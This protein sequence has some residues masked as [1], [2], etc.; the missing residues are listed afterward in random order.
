MAT[1]KQ[2]MKDDLQL[3]GL[4]PRT[5]KT[6]IVQVTRFARYFNKL[7]DKLGEKEVKEYLL[8]L[9]NEKHVSYA[10]LAQSYSALKFIYEVTLQ[11]PW[12]VKR[13]PYPKTPRKLPVVLNKEEIAAIFSV[14]TNLKHRA[15]LMMTYSAGLRISEVLHLHLSDIDRARMTVLVRQG[16]GKKDR[17]SLLSKVALQTLDEYLQRYQPRTWLFPS[18][19]RDQPF[20]R[21][22]FR[23]C[24][25][26][27]RPA[28][29]SPNRQRCIR[30]D[31][32]LPL[33]CWKQGATSTMYNC[34]WATS[35]PRP[36]PCISM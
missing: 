22:P 13:I 14:T 16:K 4:S 10:T 18:A 7:P 29:A 35:R 1:L 33:T 11:R 17:Y 20:P 8:H 26:S 3:R 30:Y 21:P 27:W 31:T 32:A 28:P 19:Y 9:L 15:I 36:L 25:G 5:Q 6:Y 34:S 24:S 23:K 12:A 2:R